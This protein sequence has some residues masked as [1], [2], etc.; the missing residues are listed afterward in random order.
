[1]LQQPFVT[2]KA[3]L[4]QEYDNTGRILE[5]LENTEWRRAV[6]VVRHQLMQMHD[7]QGTLANLRQRTVLEEIELFEIKNLAFLCMETVKAATTMGIEGILAIPD[8]KAVFG[9]LD[10]DGTG[11][12]TFYIYDSYDDAL[13]ELRRQLKAKQTLLDNCGGSIDEKAELQRQVNALFEQQNE[14]Q[15]R[16]VADLSQRLTAYCDAL[17]EAFGRM[18][19]HQG[20]LVRG[21]F[22]VIGHV[23]V[24]QQGN[25]FQEL[26]QRHC[27][28]RGFIH[29]R[30]VGYRPLGQHVF[31]VRGMA[32]FD[33]RADAVEEF[34]DVGRARLAFDRVVFLE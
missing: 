22:P 10:P 32:V 23:D 1:M 25:V 31:D 7:L 30:H 19:C 16:V 12:P 8:L 5:C 14:I 33:E 18:D 15:Q 34:F 2:D 21:I 27:R 6:A 17:T 29:L 20:Y 28:Q 26:V 3:A 13:P 4:M 9:L 24:A 11:I